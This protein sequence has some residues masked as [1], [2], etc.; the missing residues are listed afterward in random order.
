MMTKFIIAAGAI[1]GIML[2]AAAVA[3]T[4]PA[5]PVIVKI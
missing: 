2:G 4:K 1:A 5:I 3:Q